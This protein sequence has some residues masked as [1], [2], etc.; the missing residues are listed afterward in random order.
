MINEKHAKISIF[1]I[2]C[3]YIEV[4]TLQIIFALC[5]VMIIK[6]ELSFYKCPHEN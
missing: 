1:I 2:A 6:G 4:E 3:F 5:E